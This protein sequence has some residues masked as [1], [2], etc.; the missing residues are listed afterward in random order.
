MAD[1]IVAARPYESVDGLRGVSG[2]GPALFERLQP[3]V[4]LA[5]AGTQEDLIHLGSEVETQPDPEPDEVPEEIITQMEVES[6]GII[7]EEETALDEA[8]PGQ[9]E[10]PETVESIPKEKAIPP[11]KVKKS[12][13]EPPEK[14][15]KPVTWGQTFLIAAACS[16]VAFILAVLLSLGII[17]SLNSGLS[18]ASA[19]QFQSL[20]RQIGSLDSQIGILL[21]DIDSL[22]ARLDNLENMT[23]RI[24]GLEAQAE[25]LAAEIETTV[26]VVDEMNA[27]IEEILDSTDRFQAFLNGL[28]ELMDTLVSEPQEVP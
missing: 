8:E 21:E 12:E 27:K 20:S 10:G 16:F 28:G 15:S 26:E 6:I 4:T 14:P 18:Y 13:K 2:I 11:I 9:D 25:Q 24:D 5:N 23:G 17:G 1:R 7:P 19:D 3:L 22:R